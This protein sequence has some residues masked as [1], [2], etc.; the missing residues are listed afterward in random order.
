MN[1]KISQ[2]KKGIKKIGFMANLLLFVLMLI[3]VI[4]AITDSG[5]QTLSLPQG[6]NITYNYTENVTPKP[7][8][9]I[10]TPGGSFTTLVLNATQQS[11]KWKAYVGNVTGKLT[12]DNPNGYTIYD[13]SLSVISGEVYASRNNSITWSNIQCAN[14]TMIYQ[15]EQALNIQS[16]AQDSINKT[17]NNT[18]HRQFFVGGIKITNS[19][20]YAIA[21]YVN[22]TRQQPSEDADFQEVLLTDK[23]SMVYTGL[24]EPGK[25]GFDWSKY[26]FQMIVAD[27]ESA[28]TPNTYYF[29]VELGS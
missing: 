12:L 28:Q 2:H 26:D 14:K 15:E 22:D 19:S 13:W 16:T 27:D 7:A 4:I 23:T 3:A 11:Y 24:L 8:V 20:C 1:N 10:T 18:I 9:E 29:W 6:P 21:T 17:F 25:Q 5:F